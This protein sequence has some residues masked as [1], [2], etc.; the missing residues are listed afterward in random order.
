[1]HCTATGR[2]AAV[3]TQSSSGGMASGAMGARTLPRLTRQA[4]GREGLAAA[5]ECRNISKAAAQFTCTRAPGPPHGFAE[6]CGGGTKEGR[7]HIGSSREEAYCRMQKGCATFFVMACSQKTCSGH[8][9]TALF[10]MRFSAYD[11]PVDSS[12]AGNMER[13]LQHLIQVSPFRP[14]FFRFMSTSAGGRCT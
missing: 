12:A 6:P 13:R 2:T 4:S 1:M 9:T 5:A 11:R 8:C 7:P 3:M 14:F 10:R